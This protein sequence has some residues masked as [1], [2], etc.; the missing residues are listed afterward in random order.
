MTVIDALVGGNFAILGS[1]LAH[2]I[3]PAIAVAAYPTGVIA[4]MTRASLIEQ[5]GEDHV[6]MARGLGYSERQI[7]RRLALRPALN[8]VVSVTA[9]MFAYALVNT[10]LVESIFNWPG[11]GSYATASIQALDTPAIIGVTLFV[12]I[13]YVIATLVVD[14]VQAWLDPRVSVS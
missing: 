4:Q 12:A 2:L 5:L 14:V 10:F 3:L 6:R 7:V 9:L 13:V 8:P 11:L 1:A